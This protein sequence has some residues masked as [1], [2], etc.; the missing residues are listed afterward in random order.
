MPSRYARK[1]GS[2]TLRKTFVIAVEGEKD[3]TRYFE[4]MKRI[5][6]Q[7]L[8]IVIAE[9]AEEGDRSDP[10]GGYLRLYKQIKKGN[11]D[12]SL[13]EFWLVCDVDRYQTQGNLQNAVK[14]CMEA[15]Y[16][17]AVSN[18]SFDFWLLLHFEDAPLGEQRRQY[19]KAWKEYVHERREKDMSCLL[20][21][22][23]NAIE[24]A[25]NGDPDPLG[26]WPQTTGTHVYKLVE[27][28]VPEPT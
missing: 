27:R 16:Q 20:P 21:L 5:T 28:L 7:H 26:R 15:G 22:V 24:R 25:R 12:K 10:V 23:D 8:E 18:P 19:K 6:R 14:G 4:Q 9:R 1:V 17:C 3:E 11:F 2:R 13:D